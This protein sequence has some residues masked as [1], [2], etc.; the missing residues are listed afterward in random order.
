MNY[1]IIANL[2]HHYCLIIQRQSI[3]TRYWIEPNVISVLVPMR[4]IQRDSNLVKQSP[5]SHCF[6]HCHFKSLKTQQPE[7][8]TENSE[9][10]VPRA[11]ALLALK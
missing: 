11:Y 1:E 5:I 9:E 2:K 3:L 8:A 6:S 4:I 7:T 10:D